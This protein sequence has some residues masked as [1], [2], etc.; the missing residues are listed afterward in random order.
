MTHTLKESK[1]QF[2]QV[3]ERVLTRPNAVGN[4]CG[5]RP[6]EAR[7]F[8]AP[9]TESGGVQIQALDEAAMVGWCDV[10]SFPFEGLCH[11]G[12]LGML[13]A[14]RWLKLRRPLQSLE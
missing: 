11:V 2:C 14:A 3:I 4:V 10:T 13:A 6:D 7:S 1:F 5:F 9:L 8:R 12:R